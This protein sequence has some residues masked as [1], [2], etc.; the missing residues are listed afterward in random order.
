MTSSDTAIDMRPD[1]AA[2][3]MLTDYVASHGRSQ[4]N[5][6]MQANGISACGI[7]ALNCARIVLGKEYDGIRGESLI[8]D[9]AKE[10]TIAD[11]LRVC[12]SFTSSAHIDV[13]D[14]YRTP[15]FR[16]SLKLVSS[17]YGEAS[18]EI[19]HA[20]LR[21]LKDASDAHG[22][23]SCAV[24]TRPPEIIA[25]FYI[26]RPASVTDT[27]VIFDSHPRPDHLDGAAFIFKTS[28]TAA[29]SYLADLFQF[30]RTLLSD[31]SIQWQAQLLANLS[32]HVFVAKPPPPN[33]QDWRE[34][35]LQ[36]SVEYLNMRAEYMDLKARN[37]VL[38]EENSSLKQ[39]LDR[40]KQSAIGRTSKPSRHSRRAKTIATSANN[41]RPS[42]STSGGVNSTLD[43]MLR[44]SSDLWNPTS[45]VFNDNGATMPGAFPAGA[46]TDL[47]LDVDVDADLAFALEQ[48]RVFDEEDRR[49]AAERRRLKSHEPKLFRCGVCFEDHPEDY[50]ASVEPCG[51]R[52]CRECMR[53]YVR[54][55]VDEH[56]YPIPCPLCQTDPATS[57]TTPSSN[58]TLIQQL[59]LSEEQFAIYVEME[60]SSFSILTHCRSCK[61]SFYVEK[62]DLDKTE[63]ITCPLPRCRY[64]WCR[65]CSQS[66]DP[67]VPHSCDGSAELQRLM[68]TRGWKYCPGCRTPSEKIDGCNHL[69]CTAPGCNTHFCYLCSQPIVRSTIQQMIRDEVGRHYIRCRLFEDV[70]DRAVAP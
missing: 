63:I 44:H 38:D 19:F 55:K 23:S 59:G 67:T 68:F 37:A 60:M 7:A 10:Q 50:V 35:T 18:A 13:E 28:G 52:F 66:V 15:A 6:G 9:M 46:A 29:S 57:N 48:Q 42:P 31:T 5:T 65:D 8:E 32:S 43:S 4:Y 14:I 16:R 3:G 30:D 53:D 26:L 69:Q 41:T 47:P 39:Q 49:L 11:A 34:Y 22:L 40:S 21:T 20:L 62:R 58:S 33:L 12:A 27:F 24:I 54:S 64:S 45:N 2:S 61:N 51:H 17:N 70:P 1:Q 25:C 36:A 56:R